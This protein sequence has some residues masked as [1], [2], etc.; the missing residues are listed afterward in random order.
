MS[1]NRKKSTSRK[2]I[3]DEIQKL[4][5]RIRILESKLED[6]QD[7]DLTFEEL[8]LAGPI[9]VQP[10]IGRVKREYRMGNKIV[11]RRINEV[12]F[13]RCGRR[14]DQ[15]H[16]L[17]CQKCSKLVCED[18]ATLY[19]G[20]VYCLWCFKRIHDLTKSDYKILLCIASGITDANDIF[21]ITGVVPET[22][23]RKL[24]GFRDLYVT[25]KAS[26]LREL[27]FR[28]PRLTDAGADALAA[29]ERIYGADYDSIF[30]KKMIK[31]YMKANE[32]ERLRRK[33]IKGR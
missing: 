20:R 28:V 33:L 11:Q 19:H 16:V 9:T 21:R 2:R 24:Y 5:E 27:F 22:V 15:N 31:E 3:I 23:R 4:K 30:V 13:C 7:A 32:L 12:L 26:C 8:N 17:R 6:G 10:V 25:S 18:C 1:L 14:L 29:Y